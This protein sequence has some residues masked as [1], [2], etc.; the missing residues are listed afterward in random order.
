LTKD[1]AAE[2]LARATRRILEERQVYNR[3]KGRRLI[4]GVR[5]W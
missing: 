1:D 5:D 3:G 2:H 4:P